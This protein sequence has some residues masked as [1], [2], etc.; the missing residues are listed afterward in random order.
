M[1]EKAKLNEASVSNF[2]L[3][4]ERTI[5]KARFGI[6]VFP[7]GEKSDTPRFLLESSVGGGTP[8]TQGFSFGDAESFK[9]SANGKSLDILGTRKTVSDI[10]AFWKF[11]ESLIAAGFPES[12]I[13]DDISVIEGVSF[14]GDQ[15]PNDNTSKDKDSKYYKENAVYDIVGKITGMPGGK[16]TSTESDSV[17]TEAVGTILKVVLDAGG[18]LK[19]TELL[20]PLTQALKGNSNRREIVQLASD[21]KFLESQD[22][23]SV[24]DGV[25]TVD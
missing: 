3:D 1:A 23:W 5:T 8:R 13:G 24:V 7:N 6:Q 19:K 17:G 16:K 11:V 15:I 9:P 10:C 22:S 20:P 14:I 21:D 2:W 18:S 12:D 25:I 4:V